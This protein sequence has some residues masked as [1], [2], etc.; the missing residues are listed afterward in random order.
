MRTADPEG[1]TPGRAS[2]C[3]SQV[4]DEGLSLLGRMW[5]VDHFVELPSIREKY[6]DSWSRLWR[7]YTRLEEQSLEATA[8]PYI[9]H[10]MTNAHNLAVTE[11]IFEVIKLLREENQIAIADA[12]WHSVTNADWRKGSCL[13]SVAEFP[14]HVKVINR[15]GMFRLEQSQDGSF[16]QK[17]LID[18]I[19]LRGGF[20]VG[21]VVRRSIDHEYSD[22]K[23]PED[24]R[25]DAVFRYEQVDRA[26]QKDK[27]ENEPRF[28]IHKHANLKA[29]EIGAASA[30][31]TDDIA[32]KSTQRSSSGSAYRFLVVNPH[33]GEKQIMSSDAFRKWYK[34]LQQTRNQNFIESLSGYQVINSLMT[35]W[36]D[37]VVMIVDDDEEKLIDRSGRC[38]FRGTLAET[39]ADVAIMVNNIDGRNSPSYLRQQRAI[40]DIEGDPSGQVLVLTLFQK[41]LETIPR[42]E[43]RGMSVSWVVQPVPDHVD[44]S[45]DEAKFGFMTKRETLK[46]TGMV[47]GMWKLM[48]QPTNRYVLV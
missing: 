44:G 23:S 42:P 8:K 25:N 13:K 17:W 41:R 22:G 30:V 2:P 20:W 34:D 48:V 29:V 11:I 32:R 43:G 33:S 7:S 38:K 37:H 1:E 27:L 35:K 47:R 10:T 39:V 21:R 18:R 9:F 45:E 4:S 36:A 12:I 3:L 15:K 14:K 16:Q 19:M 28:R 26:P 46:T 40:F 31:R 6:R 24:V 5:K